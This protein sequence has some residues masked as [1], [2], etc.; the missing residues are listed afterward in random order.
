M[1]FELF[2]FG[3][4]KSLNAS[5]IIEIGKKMRRNQDFEVKIKSQT[6]EDTKEEKL[7]KMQGDLKW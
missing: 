7:K 6:F 2:L 4:M 1:S 5:Y 3:M